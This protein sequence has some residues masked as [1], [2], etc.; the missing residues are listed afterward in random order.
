MAVTDDAILRVKRMIL[1]GEL[2]PGDRLPRE[3]DLA[4]RLGLSRSSLREAVRALALV[5][6]LDVRQGDGTYV[7]S[8][9]ADDLLG[10][11]GLV[12]DL[13]R[14]ERSA[15][16]VHE[17]RRIL[18]P[19]A[20]AR[21]ARRIDAGEIA[22]LRALCAEAETATTVE[23][24]VELDAEFHR[25][26]A[27]AAGNAALARLLE[28]LTGSALRADVWRA[29]VRSGSVAEVVAEHRA[30]VDALASRQADVAQSWATVHL[31]TVER[32]LGRDQPLA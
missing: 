10:S 22:A 4:E 31:A 32:W 26:V 1:A 23:R 2:R 19:A 13:H 6:V 9:R 15:A 5:R 8:L 24:L 17:V 28:T 27:A 20:T 21:A 12:L 29:I 14:D 25:R 18:E 16:E 3:A 7:A 11:L 30:I